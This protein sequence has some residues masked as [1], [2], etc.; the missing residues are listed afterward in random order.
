M[1]EDAGTGVYTAVAEA[2]GLFF[3]PFVSSSIAVR[4]EWIDVNGH[5]NLAYYHVLFDRALDESLGL[6]GL[7]A[8]YVEERAASY[9]VLE[10]RVSYRRELKLADPV[11]T[12]VQIIHVDDKRIHC[13]LELRHAREGWLSA[14]CECLLIHVDMSTRRASPLPPDI[15]ANLD[16]MLKAHSLMARPDGL[17]AGIEIRHKKQ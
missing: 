11:R 6:C 1:R 14:S 16:S 17:G 3:A 7:D 4:P 9:F 10:S 8:A 13:W 5:L 15:A 2:G 12:T